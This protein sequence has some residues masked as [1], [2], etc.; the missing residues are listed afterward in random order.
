MLVVPKI[1][2]GSYTLPI[3]N[4][5]LYEAPEVVPTVCWTPVGVFETPVR[6]NHCLP[7]S[8]GNENPFCVNV[9][10]TTPTLPLAPI[11]VQWLKSARL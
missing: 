11:T 7:F 10:L 5:S 2:P 6:S 9:P 3:Q 1:P 8:A 4:V